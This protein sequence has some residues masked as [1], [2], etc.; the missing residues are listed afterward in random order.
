MAEW[1]KHTGHTIYQSLGKCTERS[2]EDGNSEMALICGAPLLRLAQIEGANYFG[3]E[4]E[5]NYNTSV[6]LARE[7][8]DL[9]EKEG[10]PDFLRGYVKEM[11]DVLKE[12]GY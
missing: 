9:A 8:V 5:Y 12:M 10:A 2:L 6:D 4:G 3:Y 11:K 1:W 7:V